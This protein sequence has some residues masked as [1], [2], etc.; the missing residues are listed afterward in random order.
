[1]D[2]RE[3]L[4]LQLA[5]E[6]G[7]LLK[8]RSFR[9]G[10]E[11]LREGVVPFVV[12]LP[13]DTIGYIIK[14]AFTLGNRAYI[15]VITNL[16]DN[17]AGQRRIRSLLLQECGHKP[18]CDVDEESEGIVNHDA[19]LGMFIDALEVGER[20]VYYAYDSETIIRFINDSMQPPVTA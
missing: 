14:R 18:P 13:D 12:G 17:M 20:R 6:V 16:G 19:T 3:R 8:N 11:P 15:F 9:A 2:K 5:S 4:R 1:M 10:M 7:K